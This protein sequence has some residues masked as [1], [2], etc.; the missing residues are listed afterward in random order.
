[1]LFPNIFSKRTDIFSVLKVNHNFLSAKM[2]KNYSLQT[3]IIELILILDELPIYRT[4]FK[5]DK[6]CYFW[7][8]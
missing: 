7:K 5:F 8:I 4:I 1:M 6:I 2:F 3:Q